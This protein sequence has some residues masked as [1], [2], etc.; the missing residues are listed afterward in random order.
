MRP[1]S[2]PLDLGALY[3]E[4]RE[5][6][7]RLVRTLSP[8]QLS[9][10]VPACP[11]WTVHDV[12]AHLAGDAVDAVSGGREGTGAERAEAHIAERASTPTTV[13]LREWERV[14]TQVEMLLTKSGGAA[15]DP[16]VELAAHE[17]DI[18][19]ALGLPGN[20]DSRAVEV[21]TDRIVSLWF[22]KI[23]SSG[24]PDVVIHD[25][26]DDVVAGRF[27]APVGFRASSFEVF[28]AGMGRRSRAQIERRLHD[29]DDPGAYV[30]LLCLRGPAEADI[31][32]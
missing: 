3:R 22:S 26:S 29:T 25:G 1:M 6:L 15:V 27:D 8:S 4:A 11:P 17:H 28:R 32:E 10:P 30:P 24:L 23:E 7:A 16:V 18:R 9:T 13:V 14:A 31:V 20:R 12:I 2:S 5:D 21:A 19:G